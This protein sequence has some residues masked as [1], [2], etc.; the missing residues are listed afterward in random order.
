M[1]KRNSMSIKLSYHQKNVLGTYYEIYNN[2]SNIEVF[3]GCI[4]LRLSTRKTHTV[5]IR[6]LKRISI[7]E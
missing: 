4:V 6:S 2:V 3:E 7:Y 1:I 5:A